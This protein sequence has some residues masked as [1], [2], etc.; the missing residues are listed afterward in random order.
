MSIGKDSVPVTQ[1]QEIHAIRRAG[2]SRHVGSILSLIWSIMA[3]GSWWQ[4]VE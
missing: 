1:F 3:H 2:L 4:V